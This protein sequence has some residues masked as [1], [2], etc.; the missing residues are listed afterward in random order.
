MALL[1]KLLGGLGAGDIRRLQAIAEKVTALEPTMQALADDQLPV[2][3]AEFKTRHQEQGVTLDDLVPETF[4]LVREA[5]KRSLRERPFDVQVMGGVALHEGNIAEM[6]TGEGKTLVATMPVVLN[7]L[8]GKGVHV[9][10]VN[11]YLAQRDAKWMG[12]IYRALG[13]TAG[14]TLHGQTQEEKRAAYAADITYG[15]NNEFG[16]DYL[17]DN[18]AYSPA[19][20][21][22][23]PM[24]YA[25][26]DEVDS[27]LIDEA[28]TPLIIS[29]PDEESTKLYQRF[30]RLVPQLERGKHYAVDEKQRVV[31]LTDEGITRMEELLGVKDLYGASEIRLI[32]QLEQA[33]RAHTLY[34]RDVDYVSKDGEILI[35]DSFTGRLMPGR[36]Y[37]EGLH[38]AIEAKEGVRVREE[39]RTLATITFQ[40][41]FRLYAKLAGMTGTAVTSREEFQKVYNLDVIVIPTHKQMIRSDHPD[42]IF[43]TEEAKFRAVVQEVK[44][45]HENGQPVLV[46]TIAIEKSERLSGMLKR[47][48]VPHEVLNAKHHEREAQIVAQAGQRG[49][50][51]ISTNMAGRG[52]DIKL[53]EGVTDLGG[54]CIIGTERHEARRIDNQLRGRAG[55]QGDQGES[56]FFISMDDDVMRI[57]GSDRM[58]KVLTTLKVPEDEPI[59]SGMVSKAVEAAQAKVE[60]FYFDARKHVLEYDDVMNR[61][62]D[63]FYRQRQRI[64]DSSTDPAMMRAEAVSILTDAL[65]EAVQ[66][67]RITAEPAKDLDAVSKE[68]IERFVNLTDDEWASIQ[69]ALPREAAPELPEGARVALRSLTEARYD[70]RRETAPPAVL[71]DVAKVI[72]LRSLDLLWTDHLD[73]MEY[74]RTGIGLRGYGQRDPLVEYRQEGHR[75]FKQLLSQFRQEAAA[76]LF[77]VTIHAQRTVGSGD[78]P[79]TPIGD[80]RGGL[81]E[82]AVGATAPQR[83]T[84]TH[85][86]APA[87]SGNIGE[88]VDE[89]S[90]AG[91][92]TTV[93][94]LPVP[95]V[96]ATGARQGAATATPLRAG[97]Q[98]GRNDPCPCGSGKKYKKC[99][100]N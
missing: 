96:Q 23:R 52:T 51:T 97:P 85:P 2:R 75:L 79:P 54:L 74:L 99:H 53:G 68:A 32:H 26:V 83:I 65:A 56:Q 98:I 42:K 76:A 36:R 3:L 49:A 89:V 70:Q 73:T 78:S 45:R 55:R 10:T 50:V 13:L 87:P 14:V 59:E 40:N 31:T 46:G 77:H 86:T 93:S 33:L 18:M 64:V 37:S 90:P 7:A 69:A 22:Q 24:H 34:K 15:T 5:A 29:A 72:L 25:I 20:R 48:G 4:A 47:D 38:Q 57:F 43:S 41:Y 81:G 67:A 61:Q 63:A 8:T 27:I 19:E 16:F 11:E 9:V 35:V 82:S 91:V 80:S 95:A 60:G 88:E 58:K 92:K 30:A 12:A 94:P 71:A 84:L 66:E 39:S 62:R 21:A 28:R 1:A 44:R 100:G 17:R 6:K